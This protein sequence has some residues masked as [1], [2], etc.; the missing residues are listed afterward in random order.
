MRWSINSLA[1]LVF[2]WVRILRFKIL[3]KRAAARD[4]ERLQSKTDPQDRELTLL[5]DLE[6]DHVAIVALRH[7]RPEFRMRLFAVKHRVQ[8]AVA[9]R[10][11]QPGKSP[12]KRRE[13]FAI[14][15]QRNIDRCTARGL[16][17]F[18]IIALQ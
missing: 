5:S 13:I 15:D 18:G 2:D 4:V 10:E 3:K 9:P 17:S 16:N 11:Q 14:G 12:G 6:Q 1:L 8:V 7:N